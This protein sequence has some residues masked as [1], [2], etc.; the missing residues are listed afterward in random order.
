MK[1][2]QEELIEI[3]AWASSRIDAQLYNIKYGRKDYRAGFKAA[4]TRAQSIKTKCEKL[5]R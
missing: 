5:S 1:F 4:L 2:T 3:I